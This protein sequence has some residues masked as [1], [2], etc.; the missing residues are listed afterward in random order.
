[1]T[2]VKPPTLK[3]LVRVYGS[4]EAAVDHLVESGFAF[5]EI[6]RKLGIPYYLAR[7]LMAGFQPKDSTLFVNMVE[8]YDRLALLRGKRGK[9]TELGKFFSRKDLDL[10]TKVR[11]VLGRITDENLRVGGGIVEKAICVATGSS[12][13]RVRKILVDYGEHGEVALLLTSRKEPKIT[14]EGIYGAIKILPRL[15]GTEDRILHISSL[16]KVA[17]P[18][19]AKYIVRLILGDLKLGYQERTV[20]SAVSKAYKIPFEIVERVSAILGV[21]DSLKLASK[22]EDAF[23]AVRI[24]PGQFI[25]PQLAHIYEPDR[26]TYP[27]RSELKHDGSRLQIHKWGSQIQLF[28][29]R[30][31]E[32]SQT[33]PEVVKI[34][35]GFKAQSCIIDSEVIAI[36]EEGIFLPF[37]NLLER[38]VPRELSEDDLAKRREKVKLTIKVFDIPYLN[39]VILMDTP[40][41]ERIKHLQEVVPPEYLAEGKECQDAVDLM[42]FYEE[43]IEKGLEGVIVKDLR[44]PYEPGKR[45]HTWLKIKPERDTVD[46]TIVKAL[47]GKGKRA[48]FY[49]SFLLAVRDSEERKLYTIGR[50]S[51]L[52]EDVMASLR[53][54]LEEM[55]MGEDKEGIFVKPRIVTE[56][57]Y[58]EIQETNE[59]T[60]GYALRVPKIVR[61][62]TD[63][64]ID[65]IDDLEKL[66][67]LYELQFERYSTKKGE[68]E[69][70]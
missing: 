15:G 39:G 46:C 31:I 42:K 66:K 11:L 52:P 10:E 4:L 41:S 58:Q 22:G 2:V 6:E 48:G 64:K 59:Y 40:L 3:E 56:V 24:R 57:T 55:K 20:I 53:R 61:F 7:L 70:S 51:N 16:L 17:T 37:Q 14:I 30:G 50:V 54:S 18:E 60:S 35:E 44:S 34:A 63:K 12:P 69:F 67:K 45:T 23:S 27:C 49:S 19:E 32:K 26:V 68:E 62:R 1:M 5:E 43:A 47:Y 36:D 25:K 8:F 65:E 28:S 9:E 13:W 33:L 29:R 21:V 38:T